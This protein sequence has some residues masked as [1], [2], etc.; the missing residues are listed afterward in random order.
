MNDTALYA[1]PY[2][3]ESIYIIAVKLSIISESS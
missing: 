3:L 2:S 1:M